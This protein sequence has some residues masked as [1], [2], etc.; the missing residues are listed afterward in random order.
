MRRRALLAAAASSL[1][2]IVAGCTSLGGFSGS[3]AVAEAPTARLELTTIADAKLPTKVLYAVRPAEGNDATAQLFDRILDGGTKAK[4]TRPPLPKQQHIAYQEAVHELSYEVV[5]ETPATR[6][7]VKVDIVTDSVVEAESIQFADLPEVDQQEFAEHGLADGD[8]V[9][10]GTTFLYTDTEREQSVLVPESEYSYITWGDETEAEWVVDD[11]Y[12]TTLNTYRYTAEHV[13]TAAGYGQQMRER[14][15]F[16]LSGLSEAQREIVETAIADG[17]Y[18]VG[19]DETPSD[20]LVALADRF[21]GHEQAHGLDEDGEGDLSGTYLVR[22]QG[23]V[24]WTT[25]VVQRDAFQ[26]TAG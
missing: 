18:I 6:Y 17:Q 7:S 13:A 19:P 10:I 16:D 15:A 14:F 24:Y 25:L 9:G 12:D 5:E 23:D 1:P 20:A 11:A 4:A 8:P 26:T 3:N 22:Y 21:R 2:A